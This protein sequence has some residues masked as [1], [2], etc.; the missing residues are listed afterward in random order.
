MN[1]RAETMG[2]Y[3]SARITEPWHLVRKVFLLLLLVVALAL[4]LVLLLERS[5]C[6]RCSTAGGWHR[7]VAG[8]CTRSCSGGG[9]RHKWS[10]S[11]TGYR[12]AVRRILTDARRDGP[13]HHGSASTGWMPGVAWYLPGSSPRTA[14]VAHTDSRQSRV[15]RPERGAAAQAFRWA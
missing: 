8:V 5:A 14:D 12:R 4:G 1:Y 6:Q 7:A 2:M 9:T 3:R 13:L 15:A 11:F 10:C